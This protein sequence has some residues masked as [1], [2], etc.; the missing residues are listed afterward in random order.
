MLKS[1]GIIW[2]RK[3]ARRSNWWRLLRCWRGCRKCNGRSES[4]QHAHWQF[5]TLK[6]MCPAL[7][8]SVLH[9]SLLDS[10]P[11]TLHNYTVCLVAAFLLPLLLVSAILPPLSLYHN[12]HRNAKF[13]LFCDE[14]DDRCKQALPLQPSVSAYQPYQII[15]VDCLVAM[16]KKP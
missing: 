6:V 5:C 4:C 13:W 14:N 2:E 7:T 8:L 16:R 15:G 10:I 1:L 12:T 9:R 11:H 3:P